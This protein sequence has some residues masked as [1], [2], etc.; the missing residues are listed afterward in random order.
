MKLI[1]L[2]AAMIA[3]AFASTAIPVSAQTTATEVR[4][5][6]AGKLDSKTSG[7]NIRVSQ[8]IGANL[9]NDQSDSVGQINDLVLDSR[10]GK[11]SY[12]AVTYGGFLGMGNKM[13]AV[14]FDAIKTK[15][16]LRD[17]GKHVLVLNVTKEQLEGAQGFDQDHWPD[18]ADK[19]FAMELDQRYNVNRV[20]NGLNK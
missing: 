13:F 16:D 15:T 14:P 9:Q 18:M 3:I 4:D 6:N 11:V 19:K 7:P 2:V 1:T 10:T 5:A 20:R 12:A 17:A 8:L